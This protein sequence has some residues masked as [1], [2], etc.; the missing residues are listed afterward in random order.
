MYTWFDIQHRVLAHFKVSYPLSVF[1]TSSCRRTVRSP[2][3][4]RQVELYLIPTP[5]QPYRHRGAKGS[6]FSSGLEIRDSEASV[7]VLVIWKIIYTL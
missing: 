4:V 1:N 2:C 7:H 5:A 3:E 6:H